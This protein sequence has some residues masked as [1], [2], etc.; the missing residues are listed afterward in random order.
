[1]GILIVFLVLITF[2]AILFN[3]MIL[4]GYLRGRFFGLN[5][6]YKETFYL[7]RKYSLKSDFLKGYKTVKQSTSIDVQKALN[8]Y[9][10]GLNLVDLS[11]HMK[12]NPDCNQQE[13]I[14]QLLT[15]I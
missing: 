3:M 7:L 10:S 2:G 11:T 12:Q 5:L 8:L 6:T 4:F 9:Y 13:I 1:M 15:K 14:N